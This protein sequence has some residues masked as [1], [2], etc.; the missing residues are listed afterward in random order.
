MSLRWGSKR[1]LYLAKPGRTVRIYGGNP[2]ATRLP[3]APQAALPRALWSSECVPSTC[4]K[5]DAS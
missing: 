2:A 3:A 1:P 4:C 5:R